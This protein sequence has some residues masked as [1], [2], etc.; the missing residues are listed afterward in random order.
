MMAGDKES[1]GISLL[2]IMAVESKKMFFIVKVFLQ[3]LFGWE[4]NPLCYKNF[5]PD[6]VCRLNT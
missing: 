4:V 6:R 1:G 2:F 3:L 5:D